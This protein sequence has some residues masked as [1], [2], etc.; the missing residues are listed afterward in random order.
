MVSLCGPDY[1]YMHALIRLIHTLLPCSDKRYTVFIITCKGDSFSTTLTHI[2]E[3][4]SILSSGVP[5]ATKTLL[6]SIMSTIGM[7]DLYAYM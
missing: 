2:G 5:T 6:Q 7:Q 1:V 4:R 3:L